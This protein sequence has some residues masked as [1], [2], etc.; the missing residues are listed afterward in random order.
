MTVDVQFWHIFSWVCFPFNLCFSSRGF[1]GLDGIPSR[2]TTH[3]LVDVLRLVCAPLCL[4][5]LCT[6]FIP[7]YV[8]PYIVFYYSVF[9]GIFHFVKVV[10]RLNGVGLLDGLG[11]CRSRDKCSAN[12]HI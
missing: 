11:G 3:S 8:V 5:R 1:D 7:R 2:G 4:E 12:R 10:D 9:M 6:K